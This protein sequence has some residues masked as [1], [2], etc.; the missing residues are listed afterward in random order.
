MEEATKRCSRCHESKPLAAFDKK[1][2]HP[3][4][5]RP[6]C[7]ACRSAWRSLGRPLPYGGMADFDTLLHEIRP[8]DRLSRFICS[9]VSP[10]QP[11][12]TIVTRSE[13]KPK[14]C[15]VA[16]CLRSHSA[17]GMCD[18]HYKRARHGIPLSRKLLPKIPAAGLICS[19]QGCDQRRKARGLCNMHYLRCYVG[20]GDLAPSRKLV[21]TKGFCSISDC[22]KPITQ[23]G[24]C[25]RHYTEQRR[26]D[27]LARGLSCSVVGCDAAPEARGLC[28]KHYHR[29]RTLGVTELPPVKQ[30]TLNNQGYIL[31]LV[32][33]GT[34]GSYGKQVGRFTRIL[35]HR[36]VM[37]QHLGRPLLKT[38][39]VHHR[40]GNRT[41]NAIENL[42]LKTTAHGPGITIPDTLKA[43]KET[44]K[45]YGRKR[46][47]RATVESQ[48]T[49]SV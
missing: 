46:T 21:S 24:L 32:P 44:L 33:V 4:G 10:P 7:K 31:L 6:M 13:A 15:M 36:F 9:P 47:K 40:D 3:E 48:Q 39:Q 1:A 11:T 41:N 27:K 16:D 34:P 37:Q 23:R 42:E 22:H 5:H 38:E 8:E 26:I 2:S 30:R 35:E 25:S 14:K 28:L 20:S 49:L 19:V 29:D 12:R 18:L 17:K 45:L 43:A